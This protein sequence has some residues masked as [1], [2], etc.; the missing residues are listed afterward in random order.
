MFTLKD[1]FYRPP[2]NHLGVIYWNDRF[3]RFVTQDQW[4]L[5]WPLRQLFKVIRLDPR[6]AEF[7]LSDLFTSDRV[8]MNM[9]VKVF[10][11]V[12]PRIATPAQRI[13]VLHL[14]DEAWPTIIKTNL[15]EIARNRIFI[16]KTCDELFSHTSRQEIRA[17]LSEAVGQRARNFGLIIEPSYGVAIINLQPNETYR[18]ALE[19]QSAAAAQSEAAFRRLQPMMAQ[20][21]QGNM[22]DGLQALYLQIAA[23]IAKGGE[24]PDVIFPETPEHI[25][26]MSSNRHLTRR[27][28]NHEPIV[29]W[30]SVPPSTD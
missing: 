14:P 2:E 17:A 6:T 28:R 19:E 4:A 8:A 7:T 11:R 3:S 21:T 29:V 9:H 25:H 5:V 16:T 12:D 20:L 1:I 13:Q 30:P 22:P 27:L 15:E 26:G 18:K 24:I 23:A 10:Y